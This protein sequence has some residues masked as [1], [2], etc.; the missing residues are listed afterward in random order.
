MT[1]VEL[2]QDEYPDDQ[3]ADE[4]APAARELRK[5]ARNIAFALIAGGMLLAALDSTIMATALPTIVGDLGGA[6]HMSWV[7]TAY[8]LTETISTVLAGKFGDQ[9]GRKNIFVISIVIFVVAS[10]LAGFA[11]SMTWLIAMRAV[12]GVG[13]GGLMVTASAMIADII[14]LRERGKYQGALGAVFGV[15]TVL[16]PLLGGLF[17]DHLS[18]R[19][20]FYINLPIALAILIPALKV[21]PSAK[22]KA[23]ERIDYLGIACI[24]LAAG[25]LVLATSWGGTEYAWGSTQIIG[26]FVLGAIGIGLFVLAERRAEHPILP[27]RLFRTNVF[28]VSVVLSFIVGFALLGAMTFLPTYLQ[29]CQG[30]SATVSGLRTLPMVIGLLVA[31]VTSGSMVSKTGIYKPF[32]IAGALVMTVGMWLLSRLDEHSSAFETSAAMLV[33]GVGIGLTMQVLVIVVQATSDYQDLGVATS[34]VTFFRTMGSA[35]GAAIFGTLY[36][37]A[38]KPKL[39]AAVLATNADLRQVT[40]PDG[41]HSLPAASRAVVIHAY[42]QAISHTFM[43]AIPVAVLALLVAL[44]LK[45]VPLRGIDKKGAGDLG[46][47]FGMPDQRTS[48]ERLEAQLVRMLRTRLPAA[49]SDILEASDAAPDLDLV[50]VWTVRQVAIEQRRM[51]WDRPGAEPVAV[52]SQI[53]R[54]RRVPLGLIAPAFVDAEGAGLIEARGDG[55]V[56]SEDGRQQFR[57]VV[58]SVIRWIITEIERENGERLTDDDRTSIA[59]MARKLALQDDMGALEKADA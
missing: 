29:Y 23:S 42:A 21:L 4:D 2:A 45:Q 20:V 36:A 52:P 33:L 6:T 1:S 7:I 12:Q 59:G 34:G 19:W 41:V 24:T 10:A 32:P 28:S 50:R 43:L 54:R 38:L 40:T 53:A 26:L 57:V 27:L 47:G 31:S 44:F 13:G 49:M 30:V 51:T 14:P 17:T 35:F 22:A 15:T 16:G 58:R 55:Y 8:M 9:F 5:G 3:L 37:N 56:L 25:S 48:A 11:H 18:W 46:Q 39:A